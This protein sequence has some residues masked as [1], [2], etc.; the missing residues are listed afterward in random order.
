MHDSD[1]ENKGFEVGFKRTL[2]NVLILENVV[3]GSL[4]RHHDV[5]ERVDTVEDDQTCNS[6]Y[7]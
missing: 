6:K 1:R 5:G 3:T 4:T 7:R 2:D